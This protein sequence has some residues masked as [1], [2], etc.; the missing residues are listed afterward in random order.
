[1]EAIKVKLLIHQADGNKEEVKK[2]C[3]HLL[4]KG[5]EIEK[6]DSDFPPTLKAVLHEVGQGLIRKD[7]RRLQL[8]GLFDVTNK[9]QEGWRGRLQQLGRQR[10]WDKILVYQMEPIGWNHKVTGT[11]YTVSDESSALGGSK[12]KNMTTQAVELVDLAD[13]SQGLR[14]LLKALFFI[15]SSE[16]IQ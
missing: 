13:L 8:G 3:I 1:M 10:H 15:D 12:N 6:L 11:L 14:I 5:L 7:Q 9:F 4:E 16:L 2:L